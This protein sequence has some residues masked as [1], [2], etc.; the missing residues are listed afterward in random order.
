MNRKHLPSLILTAIA[1]AIISF[2]PNISHG[3]N[4]TG[5]HIPRDGDRLHPDVSFSPEA[6]SKV[7]PNLKMVF[8]NR[9]QFS[10]MN[11]ADMCVYLYEDTLS[12]IQFATKHL[13]SLKTDTLS[14]LGYENRASRFVIKNPIAVA[15]LNSATSFIVNEN[16]NGRLTFHGKDFLK[17]VKGTSSARIEDDWTICGDSDTIKHVVYGRWDMDMAYFD[18]DSIDSNAADSL[19]SQQVSDLLIPV[20]DMAKERVVTSREMWFAPDARYPVLQRSL[21]FLI[22]TTD[23]EDCDTIPVSCFSSHYPM[24]FQRSDTGEEYVPDFSIRKMPDAKYTNLGLADDR[25]GLTI[26]D[27]IAGKEHIS[28]TISTES[29][30]E[31]LNLT[32]YSDNGIRLSETISVRAQSLPQTIRIPRPQKSGGIVILFIESEAASICRKVIL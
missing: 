19:M 21:S 30:E 32:L 9:N 6:I 29:G 2:V 27:A 17:Q 20:R 18:I 28:V 31:D 1:V 7:D 3:S 8:F 15:S 11:D 5:P 10:A 25:E 22:K 12:F 4:D 23:G 16:L 13:F 26:S 14:Y 24:A